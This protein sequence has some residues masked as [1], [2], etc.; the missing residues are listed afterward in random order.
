MLIFWHFWGTQ[1]RN[2]ALWQRDT[3]TSQGRVASRSVLQSPSFPK[4]PLKGTLLAPVALQTPARVKQE[5]ICRE[6]S[7]KEGFHLQPGLG[8]YLLHVLLAGKHQA[9]RAPTPIYRPRCS[10]SLH[11]GHKP[12]NSLR[13]C[14]TQKTDP[15]SQR[16]TFLQSCFPEPRHAPSME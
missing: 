11:T 3:H 14:H 4:T 10:H 9:T 13:L 12:G 6:K 1:K 2:L 8:Q 16:L 7:A 15:L 5:E